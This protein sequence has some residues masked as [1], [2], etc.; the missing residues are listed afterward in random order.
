MK[1][2]IPLQGLSHD[3]K[4]GYPKLLIST[5]VGLLFFTSDYNFHRFTTIDMH[6]LITNLLTL[7]IFR[8]SL[9]TMFTKLPR[10]KFYVLSVMHYGIKTKIFQKLKNKCILTYQNMV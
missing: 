10:L 7:T 4:T 6:L 8:Y 5:F 9:F 3:L 1:T 2:M